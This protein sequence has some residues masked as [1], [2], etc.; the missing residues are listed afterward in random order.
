MAIKDTTCVSAW[1]KNEV[2]EKMLFDKEQK[3]I[4]MQKLTKNLIESI[5]EKKAPGPEPDDQFKQLQIE[6]IKNKYRLQKLYE[7][8]DKNTLEGSKSYQAQVEREL[9]NFMKS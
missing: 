4:S 1:V 3:G 8:I 6:S 5:Y 7:L 9:E 2:Y